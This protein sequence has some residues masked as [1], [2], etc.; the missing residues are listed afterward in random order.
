MSRSVSLC[1]LRAVV[2]LLTVAVGLTG[3]SI[4]A[5][6]APA[7][8]SAGVSPADDVAE[9]PDAVSAMV[10]ARA[11]GHRVED[12]S[13]RSETTQVFA[14]P[15]GTWTTEEA[16][17][18][19]RTQNDQGA[20]ADI[21][22]DLTAVPDGFAPK[23]ALGEL[24][25][26]DG[27]EKTFAAMEVDG[28]D[29][30]WQWPTNLPEPVIEGNT[31]TYSGV[32]D[33]GDLVV[34]A[35][36][37]GFSHDVVLHE[38]P[39]APVSFAIPVVTGGPKLTEGERGDLSI[40]TKSGDDLVNAVE[41]VMYDSSEDETGDPE[42][43]T[44]VDTTV[45]Q[46]HG[47]SGGGVVTLKPDQ[48]FL[49]DPETV[50]PVTVD[51]AFTSYALGDTWITN[52][53]ST[54]HYTSADLRVGS[55]NGGDTI[56]RTFMNF[57]DV[58]WRG[59]HIEH[60]E[61]RLSNHYAVSCTASSVQASRITADWAKATVAWP[62]PSVTTAGADNYTPAHGY[63]GCPAAQAAWDVGPIVQAWADGAPQRGIRLAAVN[64]SSANAYR[65]YRSTEFSAASTETPRLT[66]TYNTTPRTAAVPSTTAARTYDGTLFVGKD[67]PT[68]TSSGTDP[69]SN[70]VRYTTEA[71]PST[72]SSTITATCTTGT[73]ASGA[74]AACTPTAALA[75]NTSY[76]VRSK[77]VDQPGG[78]SGPWSAWRA[79]KT[80]LTTPTV[81]SLS[82]NGVADKHWYESRPATLTSCA[83]AGNGADL[84]Y[85]VNRQTKP[86]LSTTDTTTVAIPET[87]YTNIEVRSRTRAGSVSD[88]A[89]IGFGTGP[90]SL[91]APVAEDRSSSTFPVKAAAPS[92]AD[93][94]RVQWRYAP[95]TT[96]TPD[97]DAGWVDA[98][99]VKLASNPSVAWSGSV[100]GTDWSTT[101]DLLWDPQGEPGISS[102]ALVEVRVMFAYAGSGTGVEKASPLQRV[103]VV[104]HAFGGSFP[105]QSAGP[106]EVALFTGEFQLSQSDVSVPG[107]GGDL[108]LGRSHLSMGGTATGPTGVFGPGWKAD[109]SGP[110]EG[111]GGLTVTDRTAEDGSIMLAVPD[112]GSYFYRH[113]SNTAGAQRAG[114][115]VGVGES[116]LEKDTLI[117]TAVA[118][119]SG[120]SH[121][122]T[123]TEWDGTKT[124]FVRTNNVWTTEKVIG[125]EEA[126]T[127][128]YAHDGDGMVTW[129]FAPAPAGVTC[130][131]TSQEPGCRALHLNYIGSGTS[132]R[133]SSVDLRIFDPHTGSNGL[134]GTGA[135]M[136]TITV[137]KY[138]YNTA[139]QL[140][141]EWD[142]RLG[143]GASA[144]KTEYAYDDLAGHTVLVAVTDPGMKTWNFH[145]DTASGKLTSI[146][147]DQDSAVGGSAATWTVR[148][149]IPL[150]GGGLPD[151]TAAN[152]PAWGQS[153][154]DAP[155]GG[156]AVFGPDRVP[157]TVP[158][159]DDYEY[160]SLSYWTDS[161]RTTNTATFGAGAWQIDSTKYDER[162]NTTWALSATGRNM[163]LSE[164][165]TVAET[166]GAAQKYASFTVYNETGTR[167]EETYSPTH[168]FLLDDG[169]PFT[170]RTL[171]QAV[172]DD[173]TDAVGFTDGRPV[174]DIPEGGFDLAVREFNSATD[175]TGP[176]DGP[177]ATGH[178]AP[179]AGREF[180][181]AETRYGYK[182]IETGDGDGWD[183]RTP[184]LVSSQDGGAWSTTA[185]RFDE[186]GKLLETR[187]PQANAATGSASL[188]R[189][190]Q[191][192]YYTP[193]ASASR[194]ECRSKPEWAGEVCW[195]GVAGTPSS[196]AAIPDTT[197][198]GYSTLLTATRNV[199]SSGAATRVN[200][201]G[202]DDAGRPTTSSVST[203]GLA[204]ADRVIPGTTT[205]Y[206]PT[207]GL[208]TSLTNGAQTQSIGY[209][210]WGR[211]TSQTDGTGNAAVT[212]YDAAGRVATANDGKGTYIYTY[213]GLDARGKKER[214]GL[215]T[216][217]DTG[218]TSGADEFSGA[219]D[220][221]G[222]LVEQN[223][224]GGLKATWTHDL[225]GAATG[226]D[227]AQGGA[228]LFG[229]ANALDRAGRVREADGPSSSQAY[230]YD[231]RGRLER[232]ED[233]TT[234]G[235]TTRKYGFTEDSNRKSLQTYAPDDASGGACQS[236]T[237]ASTLTPTYDDADR[238]IAS[239]Y[240]YDALGRTKSVRSVDTVAGLSSPSD[241]DVGYHSN[242][243]V[244][245]LSQ[246]GLENGVSVT[247]SQDF[248]L[249]VAGRVSVIKNITDGVS[250]QESTNHFDRQGDSPAW[251]ETKVRPNA[252]TA[253][254]SNWT[255][256][257]TGL[258]GELGLV[259]SSDGSSRVQ[260]ANLHGDIVSDTSVG[261]TG[262]ESYFE[263]N[264]YG[265]GRDSIA[266]PARYGWVGVKQRQSAGILGGLTLMGARLYN[267]A[268][269]RFLSR[270]PVEGG[271]DNTYVYPADPINGFD[272]SGRDS[273]SKDW[274]TIFNACHDYASKGKCALL[275]GR[276]RTI[277]KW[278]KEQTSN[279][280]ERNA[281]RHFAWVTMMSY[282]IGTEG[283]A[284]VAA[285]H[286]LS[287]KGG[288]EQDRKRD[289][290][291]N[292]YV[293]GY[294]G[295][296]REYIANHLGRIITRGDLQ[297]LIDKGFSLYDR[298]YL[299]KLNKNGKVRPSS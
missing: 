272:F 256:N 224:P 280:N 198:T 94:A 284:H 240:S 79:I 212:S 197:T 2:L 75:N 150:S 8:E 290:K 72:T 131:A 85:Q 9:R 275:V 219:Y 257:I 231:H 152:T 215:V 207:T 81:P 125:P 269:G 124:I 238:L 194:P 171:T 37:A 41:P 297:W 248:A 282:M 65:R 96:G 193:D 52:A 38:A 111:A 134:P 166:A 39:S 299:F 156:A 172:Y 28:H 242:D 213:N 113:E 237:S 247:K 236:A 264:E 114:K 175:A 251:S 59:K 286:E 141:A 93:S 179:R 216:K 107:Y 191:T 14:N 260:I 54:S 163:A 273:Y 42:H 15:E 287:G 44:T 40:T 155:A 239:G 221:A 271:N 165:A 180:D 3:L 243:M 151:L 84:E 161:G 225:T 205:S 174:A 288:G 50:Y 182:P 146:T 173:E 89:R 294:Y 61:L 90:A 36:P 21:D 110:A 293:L 258:N 103:Q 158:S 5:S 108:S 200:V 130:D 266:G 43:V 252:S 34:T 261:G 218:L 208:P 69:D 105:T 262:V 11:V 227:Y 296:H 268:T 66:V 154:Q 104:P 109:L 126:S 233:S 13:Q 51:P 291:N 63:T 183:L 206:S 187:T 276:S 167:V 181:A 132:K 137:A 203:G 118:G 120:V 263:F 298:G 278:V 133:L 144:L 27:G 253:W 199:E 195:Q 16:A 77:V 185:T 160:A 202:F 97:P 270:D 214:R 235:C 135:G 87:G 159:A 265:I 31:A 6:A 56:S 98:A 128:T 119:E 60:A 48:E 186:E 259:Q 4:V 92:G 23:N 140:E 57:G 229:F 177:N 267:P 170:G 249:D 58:R 295:R 211:V 220:D 76:V 73:V 20:W 64:E 99:Q 32:A 176:S 29:L 101:P 55:I 285:A 190:M 169:T 226:L 127:T 19:V 95:D 223:Y 255:R 123:L 209:D 143:E 67:K 244:A 70:L 230:Q 217:L 145:Y 149:D 1:A 88:W 49:T 122:L 30:S 25:I 47:A 222:E 62:G 138:G 277:D 17:G 115:Y 289:R 283:A 121:R 210:A 7:L 71:R 147:R 35:T 10:S 117:M 116:A 106:G 45:T 279:D 246:S 184:T 188:A 162:G 254:A 74:S 22:T 136:A 178:G 228:E 232:V 86:A 82:C 201:A 164:G 18:P 204:A 274:K 148:Y 68:W 102:T 112:G 142:P 189:R 78:L 157:D 46:N 53:D 245:T 234:D 80:D 12:A 196:G 292:E 100:S 139:G 241:L 33:G 26:S 91:L 153:P 168:E 250:L 192:T 24:V 83:I 129:I 281:V